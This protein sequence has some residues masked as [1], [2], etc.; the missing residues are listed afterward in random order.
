M[1][2]LLP[3][4]ALATIAFAHRL[5]AQ[6]RSE[7]F[8][9][10]VMIQTPPGGLPPVLSNAMFDVPMHAPDVAL[11]LGHISINGTGVNMVGAML[12]IPVGR[13]ATIGVTAGYQGCKGASGCQEHTVAGA[14]VEGRLT[15]TQMGTG[16][17]ARFTIGLNGEVGIGRPRN[18]A[19]VSL[20][21]GVPLAI[22]AG[23]PD[24]KIAPFLTPAIGLARDYGDAP[25]GSR[26]LV[27]GGVALMS[28]QNGISANFG[29]QKI[30]IDGGEVMFGVNLVFGFR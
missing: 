3:L 13:Q 24:V 22:V 7:L 18:D 8:A 17:N 20:T 23:G 5:R 30:L 28:A 16:A 26:F 15:S 14:R 11:R 4:F 1:R 29:F 25:Y 19:V 27:G 10:A 2:R 12:G 9:Y 6:S 21:A